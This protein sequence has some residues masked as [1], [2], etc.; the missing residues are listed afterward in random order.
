MNLKSEFS[1]KQH[2]LS[3]SVTDRQLPPTTCLKRIELVKILELTIH[4][5]FTFRNPRVNVDHSFNSVAVENEVFQHTQITV[6][7]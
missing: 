5:S 7:V 3:I 4:T 1:E 6:K 2:R